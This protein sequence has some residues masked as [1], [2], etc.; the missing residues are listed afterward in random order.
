MKKEFEKLFKEWKEEFVFNAFISDGVVDYERYERPHIL[1]VLRDMNCKVENNLCKNLREYGSGYET[2]CNAGRWAKVLL[3]GNSEYPYDM[4]SQKRAEQLSRIAVMN[5]KKEGGGSRSNGT[6]LAR[7]V[8]EHRKYIFREI[9][10]CD[11]EIIICCGLPTKGTTSNAELL[12]NNV[13]DNCTKWDKFES[14]GLCREWWC[15]HTTINGKEIPVI[16]FCHPQITNLCGD[17]GHE[18]LFKVLYQ[19]MKKTHSLYVKRNSIPY[20]Q[21]TKSSFPS[22]AAMLQLS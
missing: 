16:S 14:S 7:A 19:D 12:Y 20:P 2:W 6:E 1:F 5:L 13:F 4:S 11:P 3:D 22:K 21:P 8:F 9:A 18:K 17:R 15:Y 10:L